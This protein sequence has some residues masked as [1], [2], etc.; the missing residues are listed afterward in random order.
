MQSPVLRETFNRGNALRSNRSDPGYAGPGCL[1]FNEYGAGA[2]LSLAAAVLA[3][4]EP[5][6]I[7][8]NFEQASVGCDI[9]LS[10]GSV[11]I[12]CNGHGADVLQAIRKELRRAGLPDSTDVGAVVQ[13]SDLSGFGDLSQKQ[14]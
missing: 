8:Q 6:F 4:G 10:P 1:A 7:A 3:A 14:L 5:D 9:Y 13:R 12:E 11:D 2:A